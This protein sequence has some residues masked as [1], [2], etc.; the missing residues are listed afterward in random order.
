[1]IEY[2][3][4]EDGLLITTYPK[5]ELDFQDTINYFDRLSNDARIMQGTIEVVY[6]NYVIDFKISHLESKEITEIY[7]E[8]KAMKRIDTTIFVCT[9]DLEY[10]MGNM[11]KTLHKIA[12]PNHNVEIVESESDLE[13]AL[14]ERSK[15]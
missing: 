7:H 8:P 5:G 6:F 14:L 2:N 9:T 10:G 1:M 13:D 3:V 12:N 15:S 4:S 11:L